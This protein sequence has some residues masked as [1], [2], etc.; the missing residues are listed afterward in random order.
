[1]Y[2]HVC[3]QYTNITDGSLFLEKQPFY[4]RD[5]AMI[6]NGA[7]TVCLVNLEKNLSPAVDAFRLIR[8]HKLWPSISYAKNSLSWE[9]RNFPLSPS[10]VSF[11][12]SQS[13]LSP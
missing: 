13:I 4:G 1:M 5:N 7:R 11:T 3:S 2:G 8:G 12:G 9:L 10:P 6:A